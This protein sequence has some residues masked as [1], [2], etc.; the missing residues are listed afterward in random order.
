MDINVKPGADTVAVIA[1][2]G[3]LTFATRKEW[4]EL[5]E[6]RLDEL[7]HYE[8]IK[9]FK[10]TSSVYFLLRNMN[11]VEYYRKPGTAFRLVK[12]SND[13]DGKQDFSAMDLSVAEGQQ[14]EINQ[15]TL[16]D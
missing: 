2:A 5:P 16:W 12:V 6:S 7:T 8:T 9:V 13:E 3:A 1:E 10:G 11:P 15:L 4:C 14:M